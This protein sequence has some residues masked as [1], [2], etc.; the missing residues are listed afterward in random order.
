MEEYEEAMK[1]YKASGGKVTEEDQNQSSLGADS[2]IAE[3]LASSPNIPSPD[4]N[5][6]HLQPSISNLLDEA[7]SEMSIDEDN[8]HLSNDNDNLLLPKDSIDKSWK[9][10]ITHD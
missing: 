6:H 1:I 4:I 8:S 3:S 2:A 5:H 7:G 9:E 10:P